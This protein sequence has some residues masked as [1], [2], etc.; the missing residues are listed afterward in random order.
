MERSG[1]TK[2]TNENYETWKLEVE[3]LLVREGL[4]KYIVPG[5]K[6]EEAANRANA[7]ELIAWDEGDQKA[8]ATIGMVLSRSQHGH[9]RATKTAKEVWKN[10]EKQHEKKSLT[11]KVHLLKRICD[12][13]FQEGDDIEDHL[14]EFESLFEK[15]ANAGTKL[16]DDLQ[17]ILVFR[18]LPSSFDALTTTLENR[19]EDELTLA[20]VKDKIINEVQKRKGT[21]PADSAVLKVAGKSKSIVCHHCQKV[22]HKKRD[23]RI[24]QKQSQDEV[25][26]SEKSVAKETKKFAKQQ[27]NAR[28]TESTEE[29]FVFSAREGPVTKWIVDSGASSHMCANR[30]FFVSV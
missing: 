16:D 23:C 11:S 25:S 28:K 5:V 26:R 21:V 24:W 20:L 1:I 8:R 10:L 7:A 4:W 17:V 19:S 3:F 18:S 22:G 15:L 27:A 30:K 6:P 14:V 2:L 12:L 13:K 9:I 29:D